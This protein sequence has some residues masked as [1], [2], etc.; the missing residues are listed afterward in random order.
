MPRK[1]TALMMF[2]A[3]LGTRMMHLT[4]TRPKPLIPVAGRPLI[5]HAMDIASDAGCAPI[6]ANLHYLPEQLEGHLHPKG[7]QTI[8]EKPHILETGGGLRNALPL[9]GNDP[10]FTQNT[11]AIWAGPNPFHLLQAAWQPDRMDAL[12]V[13]VPSAQA[14]GHSGDG[15]FEI[16]STGRLKRGPGA[17][18][19]GIQILKTELLHTI[20]KPAFSLNEV[21]NVM[22]ARQTLYGVSYPGEWCD[23]G[24]PEG[25]DLAERML[26]RHDV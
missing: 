23:V 16:D 13:C 7:V 25:I 15:D 24:H 5:D 14:I 11:D 26:E 1:P 17:I 19:G 18:Y 8:L 3:G 20:D 6:V 9:L 10:V 4:K 22:L 21:W 12:L 2:A